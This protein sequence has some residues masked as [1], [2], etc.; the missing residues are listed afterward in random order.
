MALASALAAGLRSQTPIPVM[1]EI[2][3]IE[4]QLHR[5]EGALAANQPRGARRDLKEARKSVAALRDVLQEV[6]AGKLSVVR[7][8]IID[9]EPYGADLPKGHVLRMLQHLDPGENIVAKVLDPSVVGK[10][11]PGLLLGARPGV[12]HDLVPGQLVRLY[13]GR[14]IPPGKLEQR[15]EYWLVLAPPVQNTVPFGVFGG[16]SNSYIHYAE[17]AQRREPL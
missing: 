9:I 1:E 15:A 10:T 16:G 6:A 7:V 13:H 17:R 14:N 5:I 8:Q 12:R 11:L 2:A 3:R 4:S